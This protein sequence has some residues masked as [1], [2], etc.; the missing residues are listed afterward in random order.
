VVR[1]RSNSGSEAVRTPEAVKK[2][3]VKLLICLG[4]CCDSRD[5]IVGKGPMSGSVNRK[6]GDA[7]QY[8]PVAPPSTEDKEKQTSS[9]P[10]EE[11]E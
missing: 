10:G 11:E 5:A 3:H 7:E 9:A 4:H 8:L 1:T 6:E 2:R